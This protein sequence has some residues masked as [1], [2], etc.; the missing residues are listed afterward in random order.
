LLLCLITIGGGCSQVDLSQARHVNW[1]TLAFAHH[2]Q[3]SSPAEQ[4]QGGQ[5]LDGALVSIEGFVVPLDL[6]LGMSELYVYL[7]VP[8]VGAC[9]HVPA[10][11]P[12]QIILVEMDDPVEVVNLNQAYTLSGVLIVDEANTDLAT[13]A[14]R[15]RGYDLKPWEGDADLLYE[16]DGVPQKGR[17]RG[18]LGE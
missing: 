4:E 9:M 15:M 18:H 1:K 7:F 8:F 2:T 14:Y 10:P 12:N 11:P 3:E 13:A 17:F 16:S 6:G 5:K